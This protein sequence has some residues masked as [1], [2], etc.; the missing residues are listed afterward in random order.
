MFDDLYYHTALGSYPMEGGV[1]DRPRDLEPVRTAQEYGTGDTT[2]DQ[3][4]EHVGRAVKA[5][6]GDPQK[7][8]KAI[9]DTLGGAEVIRYH[10][11][12]KER[13]ALIPVADAL[14]DAV[15]KRVL[16]D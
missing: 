10:V 3:A 7:A 16:G 12:N 11:P 13:H 2:R 8:K 6:G 4:M 14:A 1:A 9:S 5:A 15:R